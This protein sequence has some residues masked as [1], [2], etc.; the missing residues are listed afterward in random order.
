MA[1]WDDTP[2]VVSDSPT[3]RADSRIRTSP[4]PFTDQVE[5]RY[6]LSEPAAVSI[7]VYDARG[8]LVRSLEH[9]GQSDGSG[10]VVWDGRDNH[11]REALAG[12]YFLRVKSPTTTLETTVSLQPR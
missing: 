5:I 10:L 1:R 2:V 3:A 4:N 7:L 6:H 9:S 11:G 12:L 8:R